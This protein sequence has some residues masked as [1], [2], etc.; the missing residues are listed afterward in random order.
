[1]NKKKLK[2]KLSKAKSWCKDHGTG[3]LCIVTSSIIGGIV[4]GKGYKKGWND[5]IDKCINTMD[6]NTATLALKEPIT[7]RD[8]MSEE[9]IKKTIDN[10][11]DGAADCLDK[12]VKEIMFWF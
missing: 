12:P 5:A 7:P 1:M 2:E 8:L 4:A 6:E 11:E 9:S 3:I 10:K